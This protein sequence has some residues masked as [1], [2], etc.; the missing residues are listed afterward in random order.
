MTP[1]NYRWTSR[2]GTITGQTQYGF[3]AQEQIWKVLFM[4]M[5]LMNMALPFQHNISEVIGSYESTHKA[6]AMNI[7]QK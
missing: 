2:T 6:D 5:V 4:V 1:G 3:I 7:T